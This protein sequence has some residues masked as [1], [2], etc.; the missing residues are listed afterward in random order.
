MTEASMQAV[1][2]VP[3]LGFPVAMGYNVSVSLPEIVCLHTITI[4]FR[5]HSGLL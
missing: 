3:S 1:V 5:F 2:D 4:E